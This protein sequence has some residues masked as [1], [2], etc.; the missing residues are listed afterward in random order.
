MNL[1]T[2]YTI[3]DNNY[4]IKLFQIE[5]ILNLSGNGKTIFYSD[6]ILYY[7]IFYSIRK[8]NIAN[9]LILNVY[10]IIQTSNA[11]QIKSKSI[12]ILNTCN[13]LVF[14][15]VKFNLYKIKLFFRRNSSIGKNFCQRMSTVCTTL[16]Y[17]T[18]IVRFK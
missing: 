16:M 2:W 11:G 14:T 3:L 8:D 5:I 12:D 9:I 10:P 15:I 17:I 6:S 18:N 1:I 7:R 13:N 4:I